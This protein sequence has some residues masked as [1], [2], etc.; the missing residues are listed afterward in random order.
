VYTDAEVTANRPD[1]IKTKKKK[2]TRILINVAIPAD[3]NVM[4]KEAGRKLKYKCLSVKIQQMWNMKCIITPVVTADDRNSN[5]RFKEKSGSH[6]RKRFSRFTT[7]DSCA[8][9]ITHN[10]KSTAV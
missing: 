8:C 10:T 1:I 2:K 7:K 5:K 6:T 4:H 9:N 3:R